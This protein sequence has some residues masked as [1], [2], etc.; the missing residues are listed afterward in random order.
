M[1]FSFFRH[2]VI[3]MCSP[4]VT[5]GYT[6]DPQPNALKGAPFLYG[7]NGIGRA[8]RGVPAVLP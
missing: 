3:A 6:P 7:L 5:F 2:W 4:G 8:G 1:S